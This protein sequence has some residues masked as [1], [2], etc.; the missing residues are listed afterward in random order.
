MYGEILSKSI[1][2]TSL[3]L[4]FRFIIRRSQ[5]ETQGVDRPVQMTGWIELS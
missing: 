5:S 2:F 3:E 4:R 1:D